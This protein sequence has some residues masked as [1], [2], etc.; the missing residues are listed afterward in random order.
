MWADLDD[1]FTFSHF[2]EHPAHF[3]ARSDHGRG[4]D[5]RYFDKNHFFQKNTLF[6]TVFW[7]SLGTFLANFKKV[8]GGG[9]SKITKNFEIS[10]NH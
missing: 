5:I 9:G 3:A 8:E 6:S 1:F 2:N 10:K 4:S 7:P